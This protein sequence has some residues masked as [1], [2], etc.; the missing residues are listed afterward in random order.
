MKYCAF[1]CAYLLI[2]MGMITQENPCA[3]IHISYWFKN[4]VKIHFFFTVKSLK[5]VAT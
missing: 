3:G 4:T 5:S 1:V 2:L